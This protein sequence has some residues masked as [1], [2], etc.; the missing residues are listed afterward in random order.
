MGKKLQGKCLVFCNGEQECANGG[1][2]VYVRL[3]NF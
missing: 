2:Y 1:Y 3:S